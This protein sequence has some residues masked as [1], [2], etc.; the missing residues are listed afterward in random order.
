MCSS[1]LAFR[2]LVARKV[3]D[4]LRKVLPSPETERGR[5]L[6]EAIPGLPTP[7]AQDPRGT[8][9]PSLL[10]LLDDLLQRGAGAEKGLAGVFQRH[11]QEASSLLGPHAFPVPVSTG[12]DPRPGTPLSGVPGAYLPLLAL[13]L[14]ADGAKAGVRPT[15]GWNEGRVADLSADPGYPGAVAVASS[16]LPDPKGPALDAG[17][18]VV[19]TALKAAEALEPR[20][21]QAGAG[22]GMLSVDRGERGRPALVLA[23]GDRPAPELKTLLAVAAAANVTDLRLV[24]PGSAGR[25]LPAFYREPPV[26]PGIEAPKGPRVL[27]VLTPAG[28]DVHP[29]AKAS[30][31]I[32]GWPEGVQAVPEGK[33]LFR[34]SVPWV[35]DKGFSG[36]VAEAVG[37][38]RAKARTAPAVDVV[39]RAKDVTA[40]EIVDAAAEILAAPGDRYDLLPV[41]FPGVSCAQGGACPS[42]VPVLFSD[43]A[44]PKG[45]KAQTVMVETRPSGFCEKGAVQRVVMGRSGAYRAC[46]EAELQRYGNL[47]GRLELRFTIEPDGSVSG[48]TTSVN[49]LTKGVE[50]CIVRQV[51]QLKFPKP[52]GGICIIRWPFSFKPG[53]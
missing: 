26:L 43:A 23:R 2:A 47:A 35:A 11:A 49:E 50:A 1:D 32:A 52:D 20:A 12:P 38:I 3:L 42:A 18:A 22:T 29:P 24:P 7:M 6:Q 9:F 25:V 4:G 13:T 53:G 46:Y 21:F 51:S 34:L 39:I 19:A 41:Y 27:V 30:L 37:A 28:A 33:R 44:V 10:R 40:A 36:K 8:V 14:D 5:L 17:K 45:G 48:I 15:F 16:D 31:P